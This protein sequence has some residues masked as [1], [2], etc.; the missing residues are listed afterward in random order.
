MVD[1]TIQRP[2]NIRMIRLDT[3]IKLRWLA[4]AG[5]LVAV[6]VVYFVLGFPLPMASA[7]GIIT[8]SAILNLTLR[9]RF[10]PTHR[11]SDGA[12]AAL[13]AFDVV[14]LAALLYLTG[15][16]ENP[17][18]IL[19][20]APVM[21]SATALPPGRTLYLGALAMAGTT[22]LAVWHQPLPWVP[23]ES[24]RL[25]ALYILGVWLSILLGLSFIGIYAWRVANEARQLGDALAAT[26][27]VL[28][29]EQ[30]LSQLDG[31]A[32]AAAHELGTPLATIALVVGELDRATTVSDTHKE[33]IVLLREQTA[34]CRQ[35]LS[36]ITTLG[37]EP[38]GP[39]VVVS[40][41]QLIEE[42][43]A[44]QRAFGVAIQ[45]ETKG[46]NGEPDTKRSPGLFYGLENLIDNAVDF[47]ASTVRISAYWS[48]QEVVIRILDDGPGFAPEVLNRLGE[49]YVTTRGLNAYDRKRAGG[50]GLGL[51]IAKT[52]LERSGAVFQANNRSGPD[53]GAEVTV[54]WPRT[55][56]EYAKAPQF[57]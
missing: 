57:A 25:P 46:T 51:F 36:K 1:L 18:A 28:A 9:A 3:L 35:I 52:L 13:L 6:L 56:F 33:D 45:I 49:P 14:Q 44:P 17:F 38:A 34:R 41:K 12:A 19:F 26:E 50:L 22:V 4:V 30:H 15:G 42:V 5:Q 32:A 8:V 43:T 54:T 10:H 24:L 7:I 16:L 2:G 21:I 53:K 55:A 20:L 40:L 23:G 11:M 31:L 37:T 48:A 47:A 39:L 27:L 29:R